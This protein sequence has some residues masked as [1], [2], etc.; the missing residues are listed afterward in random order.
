MKLTIE[1]SSQSELE[2]IILFFQT[3]KLESVRVIT[4]AF[5]QKP[6]KSNKK[7]PKITKGDKS[8]DP[9]ELF[10]MWAN[11]PRSVETIR[12]QAWKRDQIS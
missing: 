2:Q 9:T 3:L 4:D 12:Q 10:G 5:V 7:M 8:I 1:V 11:N 6:K